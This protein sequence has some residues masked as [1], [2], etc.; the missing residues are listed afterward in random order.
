MPGSQ[1]TD[2][3]ALVTD[4]RGALM[5]CWMVMP[6]SMRLSVMLNTEL[7]IVEPQATIGRHRLA[8]LEQHRR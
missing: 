6:W 1:D 5:A 2:P 7:M 3:P 8:V 4:R